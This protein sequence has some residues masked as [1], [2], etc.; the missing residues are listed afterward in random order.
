MNTRKLPRGRIH[1]RGIPGQL[2]RVIELYDKSSQPALREI[3]G[4]K[5]YPKNRLEE[6]VW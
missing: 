2:F 5:L 1:D 4:R 3:S 6:A